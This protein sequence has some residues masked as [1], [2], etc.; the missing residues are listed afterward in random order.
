MRTSKQYVVGFLLGV[1]F[2]FCIGSVSEQKTS[3]LEERVYKLEV[4]A[5]CTRAIVLTCAS[6]IE[7]LERIVSNLS[8]HTNS[9][10]I[11]ISEGGDILMSTYNGARLKEAQRRS[12]LKRNLKSKDE[13]LE[14]YIEELRKKQ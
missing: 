2:L 4:R 13:V 6:S 12:L 10:E 11:F 5:N 3:D 9:D 1:I 8:V 7:S 14:E